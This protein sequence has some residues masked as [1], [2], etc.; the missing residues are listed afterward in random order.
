M[1]TI[2]IVDLKVKGQNQIHN[3]KNYCTSWTLLCENSNQHFSLSQHLN[4]S[5]QQR[6]VVVKNTWQAPSV[7]TI[8]QDSPT[9]QFDETVRQDSLTRQS[10]KTVWQDS[11][12]TNGQ[13]NFSKTKNNTTKFEMSQLNLL[14][15]IL[16]IFLLQRTTADQS[17]VRWMKSRVIQLISLKRN[18]I[19]SV[20]RMKY[21]LCD[22]ISLLASARRR[23]W[24]F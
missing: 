7:K 2:T 18:F 21:T 22:K 14:I 16:S 15:L 1:K 13:D 17:E 11:P 24:R 10:D 12:T 4:P 20:P 9:R 23:Q 8:W 3:V 19:L 5:N 6:S